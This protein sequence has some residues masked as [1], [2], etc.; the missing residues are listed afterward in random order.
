MNKSHLVLLPSPP[1]GAPG[2]PRPI[3]FHGE[4]EPLEPGKGPT[5][6]ERKAPYFTVIRSSAP[7][8]ESPSDR[9]DN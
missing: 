6:I 1:K 7:P 3:P 2:E 4:L 9:P 8:A 5:L